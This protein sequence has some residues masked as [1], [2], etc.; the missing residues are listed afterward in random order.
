MDA[1]GN[2]LCPCKIPDQ[3]PKKPKKLLN[4]KNTVNI[5]LKREKGKITNFTNT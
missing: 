5:G 3:Y 2:K 1:R 4:F